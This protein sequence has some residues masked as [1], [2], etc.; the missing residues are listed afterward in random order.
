MIA[1]KLALAV[2]SKNAKNRLN[3]ERKGSRSLFAFLLHFENDSKPRGG[4]HL[5]YFAD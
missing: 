5:V 4:G 1:S 2:F 3:L